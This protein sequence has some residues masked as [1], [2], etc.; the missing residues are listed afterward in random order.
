VV[1]DKLADAIKI[2]DID[3]GFLGKISMPDLGIGKFFKNLVSSIIPDLNLEGLFQQIMT[4]VY[5]DVE[6]QFAEPIKTAQA[7]RD[8]VTGFVETNKNKLVS[9]K[10]K[11]LNEAN[12]MVAD[13]QK[14]KANTLRII[15]NLVTN[16]ITFFYQ[17]LLFLIL[18]TAT[19][20]GYLIWK[21]IN[22]F[23]FMV[24]RLQ[25][26]WTMLR[27]AVDVQYEKQII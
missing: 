23:V 17:L 22:G 4:T 10:D 11:A 13:I 8:S 7:M 24:A 27:Y 1:T 18:T 21:V 6:E 16:A 25:N 14:E 12:A 9:I 3:L 2:P 26:G 20:M 5:A 15:D 19:I